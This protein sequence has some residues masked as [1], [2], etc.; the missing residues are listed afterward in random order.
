[1]TFAVVA[2][3]FAGFVSNFKPFFLIFIIWSLQPPFTAGNRKKT[4]DKI[5]K[6]KLTLPPYLTVDARDLIKQVE[7]QILFHIIPQNTGSE[8]LLMSSNQVTVIFKNRF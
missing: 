5:L 4:I 1:M 3:F 8:S 2:V 6:C 7:T